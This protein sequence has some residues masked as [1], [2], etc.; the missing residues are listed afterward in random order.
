[1]SFESKRSSGRRAGR[2]ARLSRDQVLEAALAI[3][4]RSGLEGL[5]MQTI[6]RRLDAEAMSLYRHV[7]NKEEILDGLIDLVFAEIE[8]PS[9]GTPWRAA[10]RQRAISFRQVLARHPWAIGLLQS[11]GRPGP[12]SL[13]HHDAVLGLLRDAGFS[14]L[15]ATHAYNLVDIFVYGFVL[16][17]L[18]LPIATPEALA[19]VGEALVEPLASDEYPNFTAVGR[20][21]MASGFDYADEF[22]FGLDLILDGL[23]RAA[24]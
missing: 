16:Q 6:G 14:S 1:M 5:T 22:E 15:M 20:E 18:T 8:L 17:E 2:R 12:A 21:L 23:D 10:M 19:V 11:A 13:R 4:D 3:A 7:R 24:H 9:P